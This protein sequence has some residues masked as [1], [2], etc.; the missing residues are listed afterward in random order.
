MWNGCQTP[1]RPAQRALNLSGWHLQLIQQRPANLQGPKITLTVLAPGPKGCTPSPPLTP[2]ALTARLKRDSTPICP[3]LHSPAQ[4]EWGQGRIL[5]SH[6]S[7]PSS[8][9]IV[10]TE[11]TVEIEAKYLRCCC[12]SHYWGLDL[13]LLS[14]SLLPPTACNLPHFTITIKTE[15]LCYLAIS[16][17]IHREKYADPSTVLFIKHLYSWSW[18]FPICLQPIFVVHNQQSQTSQSTAAID[19]TLLY[20]ELPW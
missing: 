12:S 10:K 1:F 13:A 7:C 17:F 6:S 20:M 8:P 19:I 11:K 2:C 5:P 3:W 18:P 16:P 14:H 9:N 4:P 15:K